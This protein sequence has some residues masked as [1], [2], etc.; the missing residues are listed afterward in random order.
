VVNGDTGVNKHVVMIKDLQRDPLRGTIV[1]A[2]LCKVSMEE[3][4]HT[5]A[6]VILKGEARGQK[7]GGILQT[8]V[9]EVEIECLPL[10]IPE[11]I[12]VDITELGIGENLTV[13]DIAVS[14]DFRILTD[15]ETLLVTIIAPRTAEEPQAAEPEEGVTE[16]PGEAGT[17][18]APAEEAGGEGE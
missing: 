2:D 7:S 16:A 8:G 10:N 14:V 3:K 18:A 11:S 4:L 17:K 6:P 12:L 13:A 15:P 1:H 5:T 9:R